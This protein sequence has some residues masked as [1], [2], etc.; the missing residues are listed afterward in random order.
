MY[1]FLLHIAEPKADKL[2]YFP[3]QT[4]ADKA[5]VRRKHSLAGV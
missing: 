1:V 5:E 3:T 2:E 4:A